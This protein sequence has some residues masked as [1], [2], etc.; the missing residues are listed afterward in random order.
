MNVREFLLLAFLLVWVGLL[1][2]S[3]ESSEIPDLVGNWTGHSV[4]H[5]AREGYTTEESFN[6]VF[7]ITDQQGRA[8]NGTLYESGIHGDVAYGESGVISYDMKT[9]NMAD[10]DK[11]YNHGSLVSPDT[12]ELIIL[13]DGEDALAEVCV[14]KK[15]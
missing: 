4:G 2:V 12:M 15:E 3:A 13:V 9:L 8:F 11:G 14:L 7:V 6:Y 5:Y 1:P 10:H